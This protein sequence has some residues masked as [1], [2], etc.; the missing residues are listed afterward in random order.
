MSPTVLW[1]AI[2]PGS[3]LLELNTERRFLDRPPAA[4]RE[5]PPVVAGKRAVRGLNA[6]PK[7]V[8]RLS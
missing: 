4:K 2:E 6:D 3:C 7:S 8:L 1:P 5:L